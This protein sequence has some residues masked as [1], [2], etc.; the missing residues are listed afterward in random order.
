LQKDLDKEEQMNLRQVPVEE[1]LV[2]QREEMEAKQRIENRRNQ[3]LHE[4]GF[5]VESFQNDLY[6]ITN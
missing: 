1:I 3:I 2:A 4:Q 6:F 5:C